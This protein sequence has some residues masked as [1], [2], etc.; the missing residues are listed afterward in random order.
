[1]INKFQLRII[2][3]KNSYKLETDK[4]CNFCFQDISDSEYLFHLLTN[5]QNYSEERKLYI[6]QNLETIASRE[7]IL[8]IFEDPNLAIAKNVANFIYK[9]F[10]PN[11][12]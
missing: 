10:K 9:I 8:N 3:N 5:C 1:M 2:I 6:S 7:T 12:E 4:Y 11:C